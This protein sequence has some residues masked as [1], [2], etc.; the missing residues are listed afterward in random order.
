MENLEVFTIDKKHIL[1]ISIFAE[2]EEGDK[3]S[4]ANSNGFIILDLA[5]LETI[6][7]FYDRSHERPI[8]DDTENDPEDTEA[9]KLKA[10]TDNGVS[11]LD[12][13][14]ITL[15]YFNKSFYFYVEND[16]VENS[17]RGYIYEYSDCA[18][19]EKKRN[20]LMIK[21]GSESGIFH[22]N[23]NLYT[24]YIDGYER[25]LSKI[26]GEMKVRLNSFDLTQRCDGTQTLKADLSLKI[27]RVFY[28]MDLVF[29]NVTELEIACCFIRS[30]SL[31]ITKTEV[32][33][34][35]VEFSGTNV[36]FFCDRICGANEDRTENHL[37]G[38][39]KDCGKS[40]KDYII[41]TSSG[42]SEDYIDVIIVNNSERT[43]CVLKDEDESI[44]DGANEDGEPCFNDEFEVGRT[45]FNA[46]L[47]QLKNI[48][49][50]KTGGK[51]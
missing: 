28:N 30:S 38:S 16:P 3:N 50:K 47:S 25:I 12:L 39:N 1:D 32:G 33:K 41:Y 22:R 51:I 45:V 20:C 19:I 8:I 46:A 40:L 48:G 31:F 34:L 9:Y 13:T 4:F 42:T 5:S 2:S 27:V 7:S 36:S 24:D 11:P 10:R 21:F 35:Y 29:E 15:E 26:N 43:Y 17:F 44:I 6:S 23:D 49:Y 18:S 37:F 14:D